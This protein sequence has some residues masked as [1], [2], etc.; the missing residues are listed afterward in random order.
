M[1]KNLWLLL[2]LG[3][4]AGVVAYFYYTKA[5]K[6][7]SDSFADFSIAD[8]AAI[9]KVIIADSEG[10]R[11]VLTRSNQKWLLNDT[12]EA[13]PEAVNL[14][15]RAFK[16]IIIQSPVASTARNT[17][18]KRLATSHKMVQIFQNGSTEPTKIWYIGDPTQNHMGTTMLLE[19]P[20]KG[21]SPDPFITELPWHR[22]YMT[23]MFFAEWVEWMQTPVFVYP[24]LDFTKISVTHFQHPENSFF[25]EKNG[26]SF[27][28]KDA[29]TETLVQPVD[30]L[31]LKDY[32]AS[33]KG[34]YYEI[35]DKYLTPAQ[36]DSML[37]TTPKFK[38]AVT[39]KS[40]N[41]NQITIFNKKENT[42]DESIPEA[43]LLDD[44]ERYYAQLN[45]KQV[46]LIQRFA[47]DKLLLAKGNFAR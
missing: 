22:G 44:V 46:V 30:S 16:D 25:I 39:E 4:S 17:A 34:I 9:D 21:K 24:E 12:L 1:K 11:L 18:I 41:I 42:R 45:N 29:N 26:S 27:S 7:Y 14:I 5:S 38:I 13:R 23:P 2:I 33:Y 36:T 20:D 15:L 40:G 32:I 47:F 6:S 28:V 19:L 35:L 3:L 8:T 31:L 43:E 37:K 10:R